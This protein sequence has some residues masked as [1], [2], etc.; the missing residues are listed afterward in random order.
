MESLTAVV[1]AA[2]QGT[3][4]K[5]QWPKVL[6]KV[7]GVPM[8][9][10]V[11]R[12][13]KKAGSEKCV[14]VTGFKEELVRERLAGENIYFVH[15]EE[16]LGTAHAVM[17]AVPLFKDN[18]DGYVLVVCGDTPLLRRETIEG[19][20]CAC[21]PDGNY[22]Q[23]FRIRKSSPRCKRTYD[24]HCGTEGRYAGSAGCP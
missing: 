4:M 14:V 11:I 24:F 23:S 6:H 7:C 1:L 15:Q 18:R 21:C 13:V 8:V 10:Q 5:S 19:L 3:R 9:E 17:Q 16:Q 22:G 2:G 12:T 20:V